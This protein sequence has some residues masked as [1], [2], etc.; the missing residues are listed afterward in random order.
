MLWYFVVCVQ[1]CLAAVQWVKKNIWAFG[2]DR[3]RMA[4]VGESSGANLALATGDQIR[5]RRLEVAFNM[6]IEV[7]LY[8]HRGSILYR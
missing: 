2:G 5:L 6:I 1:D 7:T 3:T 4:L 8:G